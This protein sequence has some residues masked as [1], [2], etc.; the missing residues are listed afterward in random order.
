MGQ[1]V[2]EQSQAYIYALLTGRGPLLWEFFNELTHRT[3]SKAAEG[4][5]GPRPSGR[6]SGCEQR[7]SVVECGCPLPLSRHLSV[8]G[9]F[10]SGSPS[11]RFM[12][13]PRF[14]AASKAGR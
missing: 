7:A 14:T 11:A 13:A 10:I 3:D 9:G 5:R 12:A 6:R 8:P 4:S 1:R 2:M